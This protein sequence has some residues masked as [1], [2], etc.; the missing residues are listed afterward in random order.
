M[1]K[2]QPIKKITRIK[3]VG[4]DI[5]D[6]LYLYKWFKSIGHRECA[7]ALKKLIDLSKKRGAK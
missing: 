2:D 4:I 1:D 6:A 5:E 7:D 3:R